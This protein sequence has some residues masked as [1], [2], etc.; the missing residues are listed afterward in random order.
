MAAKRRTK[1][2]ISRSQLATAIAEA[3]VV[4]RAA[5]NRILTEF[6]ELAAEQLK[7]GQR[8]SIS[9]FGSFSVRTKPATKARTIPNPFDGGATK[10]KIKAKP[11]RKV[12]KFRP[13][14]TLRETVAKGK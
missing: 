8:V 5:V 9:G 1:K 2:S 14:K 4:P 11:V 10:M 7:K 12:A 3:G 13:A 6:F